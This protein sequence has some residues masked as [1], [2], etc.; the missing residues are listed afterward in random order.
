MG[1]L[2]NKLEKA[3]KAKYPHKDIYAHDT[4]I[5]ESI[6]TDDI[7]I[8]D[9]LV[10]IKFHSPRLAGDKSAISFYPVTEEQEKQQKETLH[11]FR[12]MEVAKKEYTKAGNEKLDIA[13]NNMRK[14]IHQTEIKKLENY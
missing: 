5:I 1:T 13:R 14:A 3:L 4:P 9:T 10:R 6:H 8:E 12:T 2:R 11:W 7:I